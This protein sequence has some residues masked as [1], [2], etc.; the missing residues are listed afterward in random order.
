MRTECL[1]GDIERTSSKLQPLG[2]QIAVMKD[3]HLV[4]LNEY[5]GA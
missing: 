4:S 1:R 2:G 3:A 5:M